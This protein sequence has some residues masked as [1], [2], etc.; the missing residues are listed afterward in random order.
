MF[1]R[2]LKASEHDVSF[3]GQGVFSRPAGAVDP[4]DVALTL[5]HRKLVQHSQDRRDADASG[6]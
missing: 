2:V 1:V 3:G 6:D 5:L 4:P